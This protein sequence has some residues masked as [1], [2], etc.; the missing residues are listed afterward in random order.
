MSSEFEAFLK[1][2]GIKHV[3]TAPYHPALNGLAERAVRIV[4]AG[5]KRNQ[6]GTFQSRLSNT[7]ASHRLTPHATT[8]KTP[9]ELLLG[10]RIRTRLDFLRPNTADKVEEQQ[11]HQKKGHDKQSKL[12]KFSEGSTVWVRNMP[13]G[14]KWIPGVV[15]QA[16][17]NVSYSVNLEGGRVRKCHIDQLR[18]AHAQTPSAELS[19]GSS[20]PEST[21]VT[22]SDVEIPTRVQE[23]TLVETPP[24]TAPEEVTLTMNPRFSDRLSVTVTSKA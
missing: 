21:E 16:H 10:R 15:L 5:L 14:E 19:V 7:L 9:C 4:K 13:S 24:Q 17:E 6:E 1:R 3:T 8:G 11:A 2:N 22:F 20:L 12:R 18:A 23:P